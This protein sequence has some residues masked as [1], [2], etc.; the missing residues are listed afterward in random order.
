MYY[1]AGGIDP[2]YVYPSWDGTNATILCLDHENTQKAP[3]TG[4]GFINSFTAS[5]AKAYIAAGKLAPGR[6]LVLVNTGWPGSSMSLAPSTVQYSYPSVVR[7]P[8]G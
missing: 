3:A 2:A 7:A 1:L 5:F 4:P 6:A 8:E